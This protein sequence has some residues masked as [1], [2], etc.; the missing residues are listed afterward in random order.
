MD[1]SLTIA[2]YF[3]LRRKDAFSVWVFVEKEDIILDNKLQL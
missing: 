2:I 1:H 3:G